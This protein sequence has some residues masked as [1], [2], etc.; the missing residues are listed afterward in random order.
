MFILLRVSEKISWKGEG[1]QSGAADKVI[2]YGSCVNVFVM[3]KSHCQ[4]EFMLGRVSE[5]I[6]WRGAGGCQ[7]DGVEQER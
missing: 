1:R 5:K 2:V 7:G 4:G 3:R 6:S